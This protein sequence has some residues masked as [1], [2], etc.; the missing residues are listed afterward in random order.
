MIEGVIIYRKFVEKTFNY[1]KVIITY[2]NRYVFL[3]L[4]KVRQGTNVKS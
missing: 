4:S 3:F 2:F 1:E